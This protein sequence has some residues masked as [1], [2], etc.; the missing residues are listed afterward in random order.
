MII[1]R[2]PLRI[3]FFSGGSDMPSFYTKEKGAALSVTID[4][5]NYVIVNQTHRGLRYI[6]KDVEEYPSV[7]EMQKN[8]VSETI[9][10]NGIMSGLT[11]TSISDIP[12]QGSGLGSSSAF[13]VGLHNALSSLNGEKLTKGQLAKDACEI[14][15]NRCGFTIGKQDQY[16]AAYGGFNLF[17]FME[18][19]TV[20]L[21]NLDCVLKP[22]TIK[23]LQRSL[24]LVHS[25]IDRQASQILQKQK[26]AIDDSLKFELIR[27]NRNKAYTGIRFLM[28]DD[29]DSF[30]DLLNQAWQDKKNIVDGISNCEIDQLYKKAM[31]SG[32]LGGKLL[33]AG[34][35]GYFLFYVPPAKK[36][37][38]W[39]QMYKETNNLYE[40]KF[41]EDG[42]TIQHVYG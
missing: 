42:S 23:L 31:Y 8:I 37:S 26:I 11:L 9:K 22:E 5:Y 10:F 38:F 36:M 34:G 24:I 19:D 2:T 4:K 32:A 30:G 14:E 15:I 3:S 20:K 29:V 41:V 28:D 12:G 13:T 33:G 40:L 35:G 1:S 21:D 17:E 18:N 25:G 16:A 39:R 6:Y 7:H 27:R